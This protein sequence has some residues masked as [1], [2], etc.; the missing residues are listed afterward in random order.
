MFIIVNL[1][2]GLSFKAGFFWM[3]TSYVSLKQ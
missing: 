2:H 1:I 3:H